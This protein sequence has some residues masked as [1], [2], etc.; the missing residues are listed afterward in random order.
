M[1]TLLIDSVIIF[2]Q[3]ILNTYVPIGEVSVH[4]HTK[5]NDYTALP[6]VEPYF[7][8]L[9]IHDSC[10]TDTILSNFNETVFLQSSVAVGHNVVNLNWNF[11][12]G[13]PVTYYR[14]LRD[15][16]GTGNWHPIDS[17]QGSI[18]SYSDRN[19]PINNGLRYLL[20]V[21]WNVTCTPSR[22]KPP[23]S[24]N[25]YIFNTDNEAYSNMTYLFPSGIKSILDNH[26]ITIYPNPVN[27]AISI[28]FH[29]AFEGM[30]KITDVLGQDVYSANMS[31]NG[32]SVKKINVSNLSGGVY[33]ITLEE[34]GKLYRTK[35][36]KM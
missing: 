15:D 14:I 22:I 5:Y 2:R 30:V 36:I 10:G 27:D 23:H 33:F 11:Y 20:N 1:D 26:S 6:L 13:T 4:A 9:G 29:N 3:N 28:S 31:A 35:I 16:S 8:A 24:S 25:H 32:G 7:Y 21:D 34:N 19:A 17:V 18:N 12:Q